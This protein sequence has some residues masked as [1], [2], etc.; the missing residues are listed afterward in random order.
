MTYE[1]AKYGKNFWPSLPPAV[2]T[3]LL[4][5]EVTFGV[6]ATLAAA[7]DLDSYLAVGYGGSY[8]SLFPFI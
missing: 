7:L 4:D 8:T 3:N 2:A 5:V 1:A 6:I